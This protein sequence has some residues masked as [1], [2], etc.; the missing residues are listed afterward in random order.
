MVPAGRLTSTWSCPIQLPLF[1]LRNQ[2][3]LNYSLPDV[4]DLLLVDFEE[5]IQEMPTN[6]I[7]FYI[8][9]QGM[10]NEG[11][12]ECY[13]C[14]AKCQ[15]GF[16]HQEPD[17]YLGVKRTYLAKRPANKYQCLGCFTFRRTRVTIPFLSGGFKDGRSPLDYSWWI[18]ESEVRAVTDKCHK[19]LYE[20]LL[21]PPLKFV[22]SLL[23][24]PK[25]KNHLQLAIVNELSEIKADTPLCFNLNNTTMKYTIYELEEALRH[26]SV[27][28]EPG[29]QALTKLLGPH[30]LPPKPEDIRKPGRPFERDDRNQSI[31]PVVS[32]SVLPPKKGR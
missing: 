11:I 13:W 20:K 6:P 29:V 4:S 26:G 31:R 25:S 23:N 1:G 19:H 21:Q 5:E 7:D 3:T 10:K 17:P 16:P 15:Q 27:G 24:D 28:K 30:N 9:T 14:G 32:S 8:T 22:L 12:F 18:S 2:G